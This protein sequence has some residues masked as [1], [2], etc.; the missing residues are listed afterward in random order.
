MLKYLPTKIINIDKKYHFHNYYCNQKNTTFF[1]YNKKIQIINN[2]NFKSHSSFQSWIYFSS[3]FF[4]FNKNIL[5]YFLNFVGLHK[6]VFFTNLDEISFLYLKS[7]FK[8]YNN[9]FS[10]NWYLIFLKERSLLLPLLYKGFRYSKK[11]PSRGQ[12]TRSN[13]KNTKK[14]KEKPLYNEFKKSLTNS[15]INSHFP[16]WKLIDTF[17]FHRF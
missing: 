12:R 1:F 9:Y 10:L 14:R 15:Y 2:L 8:Y 11:L 4:G 16:N 5:K 6:N 17:Y 3:K 13:Y 7:F